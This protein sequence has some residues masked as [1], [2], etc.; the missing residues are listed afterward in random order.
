M[1]R[2]YHSGPPKAERV[3][4]T[5]PYSRLDAEPGKVVYNVLSTGSE[6]LIFYALSYVVVSA[7]LFFLAS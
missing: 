5:S 4:N 6:S 3:T 7:T 1:F 2:S